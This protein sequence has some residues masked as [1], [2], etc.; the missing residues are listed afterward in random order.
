MNPTVLAVFVE[1]V[2]AA[3]RDEL[4]PYEDLSRKLGISSGKL[5]P[6]L[7][8]IRDSCRARGLPMINV[9]AISRKLGMPG[10]GFVEGLGTFNKAERR[11][12]FEKHRAQSTQ[13][14]SWRA[15]LEELG[16]PQ[17]EEE[18]ELG[19]GDELDTYFEGN[20]VQEQHFRRERNRELVRRAIERWRSQGQL[21]C[22]ACGFDFG[23]VY[24]PHG[25]DFIEAHHR[26]PLAQMPAGGSGTRIADLAPVCSNCH[27]MIHRTEPPLSVSE[28]AALIRR[29]R[30]G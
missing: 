3:E 28:L 7:T 16:A 27:R 5:F 29:Q 22:E 1:L 14:G 19:A 18:L 20:V 12:L 2:A 6:A 26:V 13:H 24:G 25:K 9:L 8:E 4:I 21:R 17:S 10:R 30:G 15:L 23:A 11:A